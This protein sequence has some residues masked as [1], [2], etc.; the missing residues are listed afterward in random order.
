M[1]EVVRPPLIL[2]P[3]GAAASA[4]RRYVAAALA[5]CGASHLEASAELGVSEL[6]TNAVLH[7]RTA[8]T[9]TVVTTPAGRVRIEVTDQSPLPPQR[10]R[11]SALATT[12]RGL[13]LVEAV[14]GDWGIDPV[15]AGSGGGKTIWFEPLDEPSPDSFFDAD[16]AADL[17][18]LQR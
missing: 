15:P 4:A 1:P 7:G 10:R 9:V 16:W 17:D 8:L 14:S 5:E 6:V 13:R 18:A 2:D 3:V 12:G 11:L